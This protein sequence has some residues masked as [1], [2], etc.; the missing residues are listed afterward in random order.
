[1]MTK[2]NIWVYG[3]FFAVLC[4]L[5]WQR[6][7]LAAEEKKIAVLPFFIH[8]SEQI[9]YLSRAIP[10][11]LSTRLEKKGEIKVIPKPAVLKALKKIEWKTFNEETALAI[12]RELGA[13]FIVAG[14]LTQI[15]KVASLDTTVLDIARKTPPR[16]FFVTAED[17]DSIPVK[18]NE[19]AQ[20][21][22]FTILDKVM[23]SDVLITG[24]RFIEKDAILYVALTK[25]G[26]VFSPEV[27]QEDLKKIYQMGYFKDIQITSN[28]TDAGKEIIFR[29]AEKPM[30]RAVQINGNKNIKLEDIQKVM[31][32]KPRT[33]LDVNKVVVD[34]GKIKKLYLDKGYYNADISYTVNPIEDDFSS[35]DF[36]IKENDIVK[37]TKVTFTGNNSIPAGELKKIL[38]TRKKHWLLSWFTSIGIFKDDSLDK[39]VERLTAYYY[40]KGFLL[41]KVDKPDIEFKA[42]DGINVHFTVVE[43][44]RFTIGYLDFKGDLIY[45]QKVL[46][47]KIKSTAN[48]TF[49]GRI[50]NDD[51]VALKGLYAEKGF[52]FAD[53]S[54]L[55]EIKQEEKK[56]DIMFSI[57][58]GDKIFIQEI[59]IS[60]NTRTRDNVIRRELRLTEGSVYNS[61]EIKRSKQEINNLGFFEDVNINTEPGTNP[62]L[63]KLRVEVKERPTGSFSVGAGYSSVDSIMGM[64]QISQNNLFGKGQ[65]LTLMAQ[66]GGSSSYYNISFTEPW[67]RDTR[68]SVGFD[69]YNIAREYEDFD[70]DSKGLNLRTSFPF[71]NYDFTRY[72]ITYR[73]EAV[74][75]SLRDDNVSL[76]LQ[77]QKGKVTTSSITNAIIRDSRDDHW[78]PRTGSYTNGG[79]ELAGFGGDSRF[80]GLNFSMAKWF[81]LPWDTAFMVRGTM[82]EL[83]ELGEDIPI[84]EKYFLGGID[85]LRGFESRSVGPKEHRPKSDGHIRLF[86]KNYDIK[87]HGFRS[88]EDVIGGEKELFFNFEYL[89]PIMTEAGIRG[90]V[91]FDTGNAY[92]K[93]QTFLSD[94]RNDVG[95]G[96][97]WYSPFGPLRVEWGYNLSPK[98]NESSSNF[99]FSMGKTF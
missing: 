84:S 89:F 55:T 12:G 77:K 42:G 28:D 62:S 27:L 45:D 53:I 18:M 43:G 81:P 2:K 98:K 29:V 70:R 21:L 20:R 23:V 92:S 60:G 59:R 16:K 36:S 75:I 11:M 15:E 37:V 13:D 97:R 6:T 95:L 69:V 31:E 48:Q 66:L 35:V 49:N 88:K 54:P 34:I 67:W 79:I 86:G 4:T 30:I 83:F 7:S 26:E 76:E 39:D 82:G 90:A 24:N 50:L 14:T 64:F 33:I 85:S 47:T 63:V 96:V 68:T 93:S 52:A 1:M 22:N 80:I 56:V 40:S 19:L 41:V 38:E 8:S 57:D 72:H 65:Q 71:Y 25:K 91:F 46:A 44:D 32:V 99:E 51:L 78:K 9:D 73:F 94:L 3:L 58:R 17:T 87:R 61:E 5:L 10:D 74:D